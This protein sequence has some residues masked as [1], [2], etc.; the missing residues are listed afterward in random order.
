MGVQYSV[1]RCEECVQERLV[2]SASEML[3]LLRRGADAVGAL[4]ADCDEAGVNCHPARHWWQ[5]VDK[6][7][8]RIEG[9]GE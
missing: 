3:A 9:R 7:I 4:E 8:D 5:D 2:D 1:C 6:L